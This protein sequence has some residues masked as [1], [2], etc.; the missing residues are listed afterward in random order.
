M[1]KIKLKTKRGTAKRI[2]LTG[3]G[4]LKRNQAG[5][6]HLFTGKDAARKRNLKG[7]VLVDKDNVAVIK[8]HLPYGS[9]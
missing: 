2:K 4:K 7:S 9:K 1:P 8:R 6:R 5:K 3:T